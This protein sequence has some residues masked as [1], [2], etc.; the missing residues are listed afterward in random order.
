MRTSREKIKSR[1]E[2]TAILDRLKAEGKKIVFTNGCFDLLHPGH[3]RYLDKARNEGD[4]LVVALNSDSSVKRIKGEGR[5]IFNEKERCEIVSGLAYVD[6]LTIFEEE[7]P[8]EIIEELQPDVLVKGGD[9]PKEQIVGREAVESAGGKVLSI[10]FEQ[11]FST[12][13]II[14]RIR[15]ANKTTNHRD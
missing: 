1:R 3:I 10:G 15:G 9:W 8:Q 12:S 6:F 2:L 13:S 7:T 11:D 14:E 4:F 5:P